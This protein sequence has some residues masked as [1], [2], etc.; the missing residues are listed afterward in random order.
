MVRPSI[1]AASIVVGAALCCTSPAAGASRAAERYLAPSSA[2]PGQANPY[3]SVSEQAASLRCLVGWARRRHG[4]GRMGESPLL[5]R[6]SLL[7]AME[8]R[9]CNDFSHTPCGQPFAAVFYAVGYL[10]PGRPAQVGENL[11]WGQGRLGTARSTMRSW[12]ASPPHRANLFRAGWRD[13]GVSVVRAP[14]LS[15]AADVEL[16]VYQFGS[17]G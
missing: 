1:L 2:C 5:D 8:I 15:G 14:R 3:A 10:V 9:R 16:W 13:F 6:S 17:R 4:L 11:A 12:L 7:R